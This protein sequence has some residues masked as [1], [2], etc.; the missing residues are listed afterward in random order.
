MPESM[1]ARAHGD[2][3]ELT[4]NNAKQTCEDAPDGTVGP[5]AR[6][7]VCRIAS[8]VQVPEEGATDNRDDCDR[9]LEARAIVW[10][11]RVVV[12]EGEG[13]GNGDS[14]DWTALV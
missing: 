12:H 1:L 14:S 10:R 6:A 3:V 4:N 5:N 8:K 9:V 13:E 7:E 2:G 11:L